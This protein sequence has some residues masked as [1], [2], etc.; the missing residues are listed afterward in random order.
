MTPVAAADE[1]A[2]AVEY[3]KMT[4]RV[5]KLKNYRQMKRVVYLV[6]IIEVVSA[7]ET[8]QNFY[9]HRKQ[10]QMKSYWLVQKAVCFFQGLLFFTFEG[11]Y[12]LTS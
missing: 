6:L 7:A 3:Q 12:F 11:S 2:A 1:V 4:E 5:L 9:R 10:C 8:C